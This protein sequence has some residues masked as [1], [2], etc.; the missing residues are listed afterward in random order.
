MAA[1]VGVTTP[2]AEDATV[3]VATRT[4]ERAVRR[5][6][7]QF[8][9]HRAGVSLRQW[10]RE[11]ATPVVI[12]AG[13]AGGLDSAHASGTVVVASDVALGDGERVACDPD[14]VQALTSAARTLGLPVI[15]G[16]IVTAERLVTGN[17]RDRWARS[18]YVAAD[19]ES[20]LLIG[21]AARVVALRVLLDTPDR[22]LSPSWEHPARASLDPRRWPEA[23]WLFRT[24]PELARRVARVLAAAVAG[25]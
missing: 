5:F 14:W 7:P 18:G 3:V 10:N 11:I 12:S 4:E 22:E 17:A 13:L 9:V 19:M 2:L 24:A 20:G 8:R 1:V 23:A 21:R 6:A 25:P 15:N 16:G